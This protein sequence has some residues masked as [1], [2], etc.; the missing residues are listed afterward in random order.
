MQKEIIKSW[1]ISTKGGKNPEE[2]HRSVKNLR[3]SSSLICLISHNIAH[4]HSYSE[5]SGDESCTIPMQS[6]LFHSS[7]LQC[8]SFPSNTTEKVSPLASSLRH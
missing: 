4:V 2:V 3:Q 6:S 1:L 7:P 5:V 8:F